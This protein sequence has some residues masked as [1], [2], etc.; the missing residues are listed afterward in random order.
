MPLLARLPPPPLPCSLL[1]L[2]S[3]ILS[4]VST[5][6]RAIYIFGW[7]EFPMPRA[8]LIQ[9]LF[10]NLPNPCQRRRRCDTQTRR[11][12]TTARGRIASSTKADDR[13]PFDGDFCCYRRV[14]CG[15]RRFRSRSTRS[16][17]MASRKRRCSGMKLATRAQRVA[18]DGRKRSSPTK[19]HFG[20]PSGLAGRGARRLSRIYFNL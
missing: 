5:R 4:R 13:Q 6:A 11:C 1:V 2:R 3:P 10:I 17:A 8:A 14:V 19:R 15:A 16:I 20:K 7:L 9:Y 18:P 12:A